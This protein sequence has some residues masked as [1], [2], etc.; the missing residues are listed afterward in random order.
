MS[1]IITGQYPQR[2]LRRNRAHD[3][4]RRLVAENHLTVDD[5]IYPVFIVEGK[6][7]T[8]SVASMPNVKRMSIDVLLQEAEQVAKLGIPVLSLFPAIEPSSKSLLSEEA[9]NENGLI[10][11]SIRSLK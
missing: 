1:S 2:R 8:Q 7:I 5:L 10:P 6:N 9:Y 4:S 11:N 3:F